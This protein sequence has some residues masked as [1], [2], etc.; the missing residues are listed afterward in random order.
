[1]APIGAAKKLAISMTLTPSSG[2]RVAGCAV[3]SVKEAS[4]VSV[5][6]LTYTLLDALSSRF[7]SA[8]ACQTRDSAVGNIETGKLDSAAR[9][10]LRHGPNA[11]GEGGRSSR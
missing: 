9:P 11:Y 7:E 4:C 3:R 10:C 5:F 8:P 2:R 6:L 1:M